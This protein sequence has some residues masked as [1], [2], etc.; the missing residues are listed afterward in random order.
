MRVELVHPDKDF[1]K[2]VAH[3][4][5]RPVFENG[6][7]SEKEKPITNGA[8][9]LSSL[10]PENVV[11]ARSENYWDREAVKLEYGGSGHAILPSVRAMLGV[12]AMSFL[13]YGCWGW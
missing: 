12:L 2:L 1:P 11:L 13:V 4:I 10:G 8:F 9:R 3:P 7:N 5:F 6:K